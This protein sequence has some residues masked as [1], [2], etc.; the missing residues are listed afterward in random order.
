M[1]HVHLLIFY[2]LPLCCAFGVQI[3]KRFAI[4]IVDVNEPPVSISITDRDAQL[5]YQ[6][7]CGYCYLLQQ[8]H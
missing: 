4:E 8:Y 3:T 7:V 1:R 2:P 6:Q 5:T